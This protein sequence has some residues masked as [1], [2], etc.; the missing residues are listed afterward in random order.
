[1][2]PTDFQKPVN[3]NGPEPAAGYSTVPVWLVVVFGALFYWSQL[4]LDKHA[5][6]FNKDVYAPYGLFG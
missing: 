5:G 3:Q 4:Y 6:G 1:M 2:N